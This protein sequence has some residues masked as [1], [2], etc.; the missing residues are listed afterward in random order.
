MKFSHAKVGVIVIWLFYSIIQILN[1][2]FWQNLLYVSLFI[3]L[4]WLLPGVLGIVI[5]K[6]AGFE[7]E[8]FFLQIEPLSLKG[9]LAIGAIYLFYPFILLSGQWIGFNPIEVL[10]IAPISGITQE[11][12]F[13]AVLL[14]T[15]L[16]HFEDNKYQN[17]LAIGIHAI[18]FG[19]W[20]MGVIWVA[21]IGGAI[22]VILVPT[23]FSLLWAWQV[24]EDKTILYI[25][26]VHISLLVIM[27][28][29]T[30]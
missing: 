25:V 27:S 26:L 1:I 28:F 10:I 30:W 20:H 29:F 22:S 18:L 19:I 2:I 11:L 9:G 16:K 15:L 13:R 17:S 3:A 24:K 21:P 12:F 8:D 14:P 23:L 5:L 6:K 7:R 4:L